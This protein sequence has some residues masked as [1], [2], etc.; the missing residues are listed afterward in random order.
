MKYVSIVLIAASAAMSGVISPGLIEAMES[1]DHTELHYVLIKPEGTVDTDYIAR[2]TQGMT[3]D[4]RREF[5]AQVMK[6]RAAS[7]Q[8]GILAQLG[9]YGG[10]MVRDVRPLWIVNAVGARLSSDVIREIAMRDDVL[11]VRPVNVS[12]A[13]IEPVD[14]RP[15]TMEEGSRD[16]A[17]GVS[18][19]GADD[20]WALGYDGSGVLVSVVD[21]GVNY[22]HLDLHNNMWHDTPAGY[23][24]GWDFDDDDGD[25]MDTYGHGTHCAGSVAGD[26]TAG[27]QTGVAPGATIMALRVG[28]SFSDELDVWEAF[29]FSIDFE[30]DVISTSLGWP[31]S[32]S[33]DRA[34]WRESEQNILAAGICHSIAAGNE[35]GDPYSWG[36]IRTPG[37]CP[38]PWLHPEQ[39]TSGGLSAVVTVGAT[40]SND[41]IAYFSS[42]GYSTWMYDSPWF[43]YPDASPDIGLIDP[44]I[45]GPG[46]DIVS[47]NYSNPSGY[48]TMS[49]TSMATPHLAGVMALVLQ[50]NPSLSPAQVDSIIEVTALDLGDTG[51]D[52]IFGSG[53][54]QALEA[55]QAALEVPVAGGTQQ[56]GPGGLLLARAGENPART[57]VMFDLYTGSAVPVEISV[58]DITGRITGTVHA[59]PLSSGSHSFT[60]GV[61]EGMGNGVYFLVASSTEG[62][63]VLRFTIL[64]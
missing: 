41:N 30:A 45:S 35:S 24:Y 46:V 42:V 32:A 1:S 26:G 20:V 27:T 54:V 6:D 43:D 51:K 64:R 39:T 2:A 47:C 14:V 37:D 34:T 61:P 8:E 57:S 3:R 9:Q 33:P 63:A 7:A 44:D 55:V 4:E 38:P 23:H 12:S 11:F 36:D 13:L 19:I 17:W 22:N 28:V 15:A 58:Y 25:P 53:R 59:G 52:N 50:A 16:I 40:D 21:T 56:G 5:A 49:G 18:K 60:W 62:S 48:T 29:Q 31:Q 10:D